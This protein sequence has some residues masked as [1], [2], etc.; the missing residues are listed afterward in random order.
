MVYTSMIQNMLSALNIKVMLNTDFKE[1]KSEL[2]Y[3]KLYYS[4]SIDEYYDYQMANCHIA[5]CNLK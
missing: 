3:E 2:E 5:V 4:G 1:I